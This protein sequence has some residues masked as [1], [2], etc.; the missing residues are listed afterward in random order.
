MGQVGRADEEDVHAV[1]PGDLVGLLERP[2]RLDLDDPDD[3]LVQPMDV[4]MAYGAEARPAHAGRD[5]T[6]AVWRIAQE[7]DGFAGVGR[8]LESGHH[9]PERPHVERSADS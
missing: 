7:R 3:A 5:A 1:D 9:D 6:N 8:A 4:G 2:G